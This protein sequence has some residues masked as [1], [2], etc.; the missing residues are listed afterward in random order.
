MALF[1]RWK[2]RNR[3]LALLWFVYIVAYIDRANFNVAAPFIQDALQFTSG[4]M[5]M[6]MSAFLIGY[7]WFQVFGGIFADKFGARKGMAFAIFWWSVCT[8]LT[9][10]AWGFISLVV[11]RFVFGVGESFHPPAS[12]KA[13]AVW[14]PRRE[15]LRANSLMLCALALAPAITPFFVVT[16]METFGWREVFY[17]FSIPGFIVAWL[18]WRNLHDDPA[19]HPDMTKAELAEIYDGQTKEQRERKISYRE[20]FKT[21]GLL[22]FC[23]TYFFFDMTFWGFFSWLPSYLVK[24]RD[25][26]LIKISIYAALPFFAGFLGLLAANFLYKKIF[27]NNKKVFLITIWLVGAVSMYFAYAAQNPQLCVFFLSLTS[28]SAIYMGFAPFWGLVTE[29]LPSQS[30]GFFSSLIN[31]AGKIGGALAPMGIGFL[32]DYTGSYGAGFAMMEVCLVI[33]S[34]LILLIKEPQHEKVEEHKL[35]TV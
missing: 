21:P 13:V 16:C 15:R 19:D 26:S 5:G 22:L 34:G 31:A 6:I 8:I 18:I 10:A 35:K 30:M 32:I 27:G 20:A 25:F 11:I 24:V 14:F 3:T 1:S 23:V 12:F 17:F 4:Q 7:G 28:F 29:I 2:V 9:G 33:A